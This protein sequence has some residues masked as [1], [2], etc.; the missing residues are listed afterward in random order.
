MAT[1]K[2]AGSSASAS[3]RRAVDEPA[4]PAVVD[5]D[6]PAAAPAD[7]GAAAESTPP[8]PRQPITRHRIAPRPVIRAGGYVLTERGWVPD[9]EQES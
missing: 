3:P 6:A 8:A 2:R 9:T 5:S 1:R 7:P 4:T